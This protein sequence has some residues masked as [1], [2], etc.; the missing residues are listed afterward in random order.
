MVAGEGK[1]LASRGKSDRFTTGSR[2][3]VGVE[4]FGSSLTW[5]D[6]ILPVSKGV[7]DEAQNDSMSVSSDRM[8]F[9]SKDG[10][11]GKK[12]RDQ[13]DGE[14]RGFRQERGRASS[15]RHHQ[16]DRS[17]PPNC[18]FCI[19]L[20]PVFRVFRN[21]YLRDNVSHRG[22]SCLPLQDASPLFAA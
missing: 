9:E 13:A 19:L 7:S 16:S 17:P 1:G 14:K 2:E 3:G 4:G 15:P 18:D 12:R 5:C 10:L 6:G 20:A 11:E 8:W 21:Q 22:G